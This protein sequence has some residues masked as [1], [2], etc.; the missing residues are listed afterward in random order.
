MKIVSPELTS[1]R[2]SPR[3]LVSPV[4]PA[5]AATAQSIDDGFTAHAFSTA[6][7]A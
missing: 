3:S 5:A 7:S 4:T 6:R 2:R 1:S